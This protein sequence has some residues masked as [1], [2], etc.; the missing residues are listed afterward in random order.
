[1]GVCVCLLSLRLIVLPNLQVATLLLSLTFAYDVF[2]VFISPYVFS[3]S[4]MEQVGL[5]NVMHI[6]CILYISF[7]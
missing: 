7:T 6:Y 2:F 4:V 5:T 1:M 3:S